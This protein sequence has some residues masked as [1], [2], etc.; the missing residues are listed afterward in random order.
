MVANAKEGARCVNLIAMHFDLL[1]NPPLYI[2]NHFPIVT[3][4]L[5]ISEVEELCD[6]Q[7]EDTRLS[8]GGL[9]YLRSRAPGCTGRFLSYFEPIQNDLSTHVQEDWPQWR[10]HLV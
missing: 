4:K 3:T 8:W 1:K 2:Q 5:S 10:A 6:D 7:L 9:V